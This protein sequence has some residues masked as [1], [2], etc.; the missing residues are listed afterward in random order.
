MPS[1]EEL[2]EIIEMRDQTIEKLQSQIKVRLHKDLLVEEI[3]KLQKLLRRND[4]M[5][6][7][8]MPGVKHIVLN[9]GELNDL[10]TSNRLQIDR[11]VP[12][13]PV[14]SSRIFGG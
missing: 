14:K 11:P 10:L 12:A 2:L 7:K 6:T 8:M 4:D 3:G 5:I 13:E 9:I 1:N